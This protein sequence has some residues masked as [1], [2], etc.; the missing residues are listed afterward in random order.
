MLIWRRIPVFF[1]V[2]GNDGG[3][4]EEKDRKFLAEMLDEF[5]YEGLQQAVISSPADKTGIVKVK[6]RPVVLKGSL[7]F[8]AEEIRGTQA[9]LQKYG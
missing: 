2:T 3:S 9:F 5:L 1:A 6:I 7:M 8:Q 4:M